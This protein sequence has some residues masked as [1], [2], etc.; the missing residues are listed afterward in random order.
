MK[1]FQKCIRK[2]PKLEWAQH[3]KIFS[4]E[5]FNC[6]FSDLNK[7][8]KN[9]IRKMSDLIQLSHDWYFPAFPLKPLVLVETKL[10]EQFNLANIQQTT[11]SFNPT[12]LELNRS[13]SPW[14]NAPHSAIEL[15]GHFSK[16]S[17]SDSQLIQKT[18][19]KF[20]VISLWNE[21][22]VKIY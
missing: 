17:T 11:H 1:Q 21:K 20:L 22:G 5:I 10:W 18:N 13:F 15:R 6:R 4:G 8:V 12:P 7:N 16:G 3:K 19:V 2:S 9:R 14:P